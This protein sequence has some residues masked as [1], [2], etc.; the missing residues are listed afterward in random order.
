[1]K[2]F[3]KRRLSYFT[4]LFICFA[5]I[6][7]VPVAALGTL[8]YTISANVSMSNLEYLSMN[9]VDKATLSLDRT[10]DEYRSAL[11]VF[12]KDDEMIQM[13]NQNKV[14]DNNRT[15]IYQKMYI[16][17]AG[18]SSKV[19]MHVIKADGSFQ[20]STSTI[21]DVYDI[22]NHSDWGVYRKINASEGTVTYSNRYIAQGGKSYCMAIA[23]SIKSRGET[24]AYAIIDIPSDVFQTALDAVNVS[25]PARYA[26]VDE[27]NYFLYDEIFASEEGSFLDM[28]FR[29]RMLE[30]ERS[31]KL[32]LDEPRRFLT[33]N[34]TKGDYP[35]RIISSI[36]VELVVLNSNYIMVTTFAVAICSILLCLILSP[37]IVRNLTK[38]LNA[39]VH[40]MDRVQGGDTEARVT[41]TNDDEF[42]YIGT[43]LNAMLDK[44]NELFAT[45]LEKQNRLRLSE[46]KALYAQINP[47]FLYNTLDSIKWLAKLNGVNDIVI[48]VSQLGKLL[49]NSIRNQKDSVQISEEI[50]LV[51]SYLA[52]QKVRY[53]EKFDVEISVEEEILSCIVPKFIIQPIVENAIIHGIE[54]KITKA[55]LVIKG[56]RENDKIIFEIKDDGVGISKENLARIRNLTHTETN[57]SDSIGIA[58]VDK[59]IKLYYGEEYGLN[60]A[61]MENVG[62]IARISMPF[63]DAPVQDGK[64]G[65]TER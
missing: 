27:N 14:T 5:V 12:C 17:L 52:I 56:W 32:Y 45:N 40:T 34:T 50:G 23:H 55:H 24:I 60:I 19:A 21:P 20:L 13:L 42:G 54:D 46:M 28:D 33:W 30:A 22:Q 37:L 6:S 57:D 18:K 53:G 47:H 3:K 25:L 31:K 44:L 35:L 65:L 36:T 38:P 7:I 10:M 1:M 29:N 2:P 48:I 15:S 61:S 51:R 41:V 43:S 8:I 59:R 4:K 58:N 26:V 39:I 49:K 11:S 62:T 63:F 9:T 16:L 64:E